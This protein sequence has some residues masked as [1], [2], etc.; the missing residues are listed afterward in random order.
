VHG[1]NGRSLSWRLDR[2]MTA[3]VEEC[4]ISKSYDCGEEGPA[5]CFV[6]L[7]REISIRLRI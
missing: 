4:W 2:V 3:C 5:G 6:W 7:A 1:V